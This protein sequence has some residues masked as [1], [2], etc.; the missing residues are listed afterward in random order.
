MKRALLLSLIALIGATAS[1]VEASM[2]SIDDSVKATES[3]VKVTEGP[4]ELENTDSNLDEPTYILCEKNSV[5]RTVRVENKKNGGCITKYSKEGI[6]QVI[7]E[8][9]SS[10]KCRSY[11]KNVRHNLGSADWKCR[12]ISKAR[13]SSASDD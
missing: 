4:A 6:E 1:A 11:L 2:K 3:V 13:V 8:S 10:S 9:W 5:V 12:D 7:G